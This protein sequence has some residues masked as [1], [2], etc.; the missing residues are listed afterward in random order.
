MSALNFVCPP[1][2]SD[3]R[4]YISDLG[5]ILVKDYGKKKYYKPA[6]VKKAH[7]KSDWSDYDFSCWGM[8]TYSSRDEFDQYHRETGEVCD[9]TSMK[10]QMLEGV[11]LTD[12]VD[13]ADLKGADLDASWLDIGSWF[14]GIWDGIGAFF[15]S[16]SG[17][18]GAD[19][20]IDTDVDI[21]IDE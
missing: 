19:T 11:S 21:D 8:S 7:K 16:I 17:S 1:A 20:D 6:E 12:A 10:T 5:K 2:P 15:S 9:Y 3:K 13:S 18:T 4:K 14:G